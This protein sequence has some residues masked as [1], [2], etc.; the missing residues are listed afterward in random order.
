MLDSQSK[1]QSMSSSPRQKSKLSSFFPLPNCSN[2]WIT[3]FACV[4]IVAQ[5]VIFNLSVVV[6]QSNGTSRDALFVFHRRSLRNGDGRVHMEDNKGAKRF[7]SDTKDADGTFNGYPVHFRSKDAVETLSHCVG[8]N[9]QKDVSWMHRSC[10]FDFFCFD[11]QT[12]DYVV[13]QYPDEERIVS[14]IESQPF[15]DVSQSYLKQSK[16]RTNTVSLGGINLKWTMDKESGIPRLEWA[17]EIRIVKPNEIVSFYELPPNVVMIPFHSMNGANPGHLVWDDFLP[18]YTLL[19]MFQLEE[20]TDLLM[21]RYVLKDG[22]RGLWASC[23]WNDERKGACHKM[24]NKFLPLMMGASPIH[25]LTTTESFNF[26]HTDGES[27]SSLVCAKHGLAGIGALTDHGTNK[28]HGWERIDYETTHNHGRGGM[29]YEFRN[30]MLRN[31]GLPIELEHKPPFRVLFSENSS[32]ADYRNFDFSKQK[33]LLQ[34]SFHPSYVSIDSIVFSEVSLEEQLQIA[35]QTS[36]LISACGG[37]AVTSMFLPKGSSVI[38]YYAEDGGVTNNK[39]TWLP[40]RLDWDL[41]NNLAYL[42]VHWLPSGTMELDADMRALLLLIQHELD[43]LIRERS[44][45]HFFN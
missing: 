8:E 21:M 22:I 32:N 30:F 15:F 7:A 37:G 6:L 19:T 2:G 39:R 14:Q 17:P 3:I 20:D 12:K 27:R 40:A 31:L 34:E 18:I 5:L 24:Q 36:I 16:N 42:K 33:K 9:Y 38:L 4:L 45:D 23:D 25:E 26:V 44:Y 1:S 11:T 43:A 13:F 28:L 35:S 10:E 29:I 41:F